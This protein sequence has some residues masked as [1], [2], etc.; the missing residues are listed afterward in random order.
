MI[1]FATKF[2]KK[3]ISELSALVSEFDNKWNL[4]QST[5]LIRHGLQNVVK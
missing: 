4:V 1:D 5:K 3:E 2:A